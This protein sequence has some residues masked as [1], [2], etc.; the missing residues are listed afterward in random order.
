MRFLDVCRNLVPGDPDTLSVPYLLI[1]QGDH[2]DVHRSK[3]VIPLMRRSAA[4][5][6]I[7]DVM[8]VVEVAGEAFVAMAPEM[9]AVSVREIGPVVGSLLDARSEIRRAIDVLTGDL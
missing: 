9:A 3:L 6:P 4:P 5:K 1:V 7:R 8:P 2:V